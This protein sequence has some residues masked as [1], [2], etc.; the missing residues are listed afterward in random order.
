M[1]GLVPPEG[2]PDLTHRAVRPGHALLASRPLG[3]GGAPLGN[4]GEEISDDTG[5]A[6]VDT[7][8]D[9]GL[10]HFDTAPHYGLG[11]SERRLGRSLGRRR[12]DEF[13]LSTKVGRLLLP[14]PE[15]A[16]SP[17]G[18]F[19]VRAT[20]RREWDFSRDGVLR[21]FESSLDR[22]G[23]DRVDIVYLHDP[24]DQWAE[25]ASSGVD[26]LVELREQGAIGA[27]GVGMNQSAMLADFVLRCDIDVVMVA[28][29]FTLL[30]Q[31]ALDDLLPA[32][33]ERGVAV[34]AAAV[35]NSGLLSRST[36]DGAASYNYRQAPPD[37]LQRARAIAAICDEHGVDLPTAALA[38]PRRHPAVV[39]VVAGMRTA[40]EA[41]EN[42]ERAAQP[43]PASLW[44]HLELAG[45]VRSLR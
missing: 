42:A 30:E 10:R 5:A 28:G 23:V 2:G 39:S 44:E 29:R 20:H 41:R 33:T 16:D 3:F 14:S 8:W 43:V 12:R 4:L 40:H 25:A 11:L 22:L 7:A 36:V 37:V 35:F 9:A 24:D 13:V 18:R 27:V 38:F 26:T 21:S 45:L 31:G 6:A 19:L 1:F 17:D 34:V 32:A 15:T